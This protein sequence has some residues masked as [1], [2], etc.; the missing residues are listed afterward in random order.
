MA[1]PTT[2]N[3]SELNAVNQILAS[4]GQAP[5][6]TLD[7]TNPDVAICYMTLKE[8]SRQV[9]AE[10]W[11]FNKE[12]NYPDQVDTSTRRYKIPNNMLQVDL[13]ECRKWEYGKYDSVRRTPPDEKEAYLYER[14]NHKY[15]W[16]ED[17]LYLDVVWL[18]S[19]DDLPI[20]VQEYIIAK[21]ATIV[22]QRIITDNNL[23]TMLKEQENYL[24]AQALEY[25]AN[26]GDFTYFGHPQGQDYYRS[27][28]PF[29]ALYR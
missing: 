26:Q 23:Y 25:E 13:A 18:W 28:Q 12:F 2:G 22:S 6:T 15:E 7:Q 20:P 8:T 17:T 16:D 4:V 3:T 9:Q 1:F 14:N 5:V 19:W 10:G 27:Y 11:T 29:Q 21:A 24:R